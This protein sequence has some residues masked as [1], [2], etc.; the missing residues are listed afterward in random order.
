MAGMSY[1]T[2]MC[3]V[4][5][6]RDFWYVLRVSV[7]LDTGSCQL[8]CVSVQSAYAYGTCGI[9][10]QGLVCLLATAVYS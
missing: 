9:V 1:M 5:D 4:T 2:V 3:R 8:A 7:D 6:L 10:G